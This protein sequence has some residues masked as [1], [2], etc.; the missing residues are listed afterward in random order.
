MV[1][2]FFYFVPPGLPYSGALDPRFVPPALLEYSQVDQGKR[3]I[4]LTCYQSFEAESIKDENQFRDILNEF[5]KEILETEDSVKKI[6][7]S[8]EVWA[9]SIHDYFCIEGNSLKKGNEL[10]LKDH[11]TL[12][13]NRTRNGFGIIKSHN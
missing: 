4:F 2:V 13:P 11:W 5:K 9:N 3:K 10:R 7:T 12:F 1:T 6:S 8:Y